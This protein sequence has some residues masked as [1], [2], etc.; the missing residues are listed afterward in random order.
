M[1]TETI[2]FDPSRHLDTTADMAMYLDM[3]LEYNDG[4][5]LSQALGDIARSRGMSDL[6]RQTGLSRESLYRALSDQGNP[7]LATLMK[8]FNALGLRLSV[9]EREEPETQTTT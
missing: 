9:K 4:R 8:I 5:L 6:A 3:V 1:S 7:N 2:P